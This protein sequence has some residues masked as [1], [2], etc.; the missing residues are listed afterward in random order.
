M[1]RMKRNCLCA[2]QKKIFIFV[3][4]LEFFSFEKFSSSKSRENKRKKLIKCGWWNNK[5]RNERDY[6]NEKELIIIIII[7][8][9]EKN[10]VVWGKS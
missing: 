1:K 7:F 6:G 2:P 10:F 4:K 5:E 3:L 8:E 9:L